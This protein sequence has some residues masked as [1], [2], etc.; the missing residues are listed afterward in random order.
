ME[1]TTILNT[2]V[3]IALGYLGYLVYSEVMEQEAK[4]I[5]NSKAIIK[6]GEV[7]IILL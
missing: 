4:K 1:F 7:H 5:D 3:G 2:A 6:D